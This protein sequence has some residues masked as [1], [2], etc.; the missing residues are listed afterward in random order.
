MTSHEHQTFGPSW[1]QS[2]TKTV[3]H[4]S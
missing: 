3:S 1:R 4:K 2:R